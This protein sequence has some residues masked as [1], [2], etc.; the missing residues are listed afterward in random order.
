MQL[1]ETCTRRHRPRSRTR[2]RQKSPL[3]STFPKKSTVQNQSA[4]G[5][6]RQPF[7]FRK[8][9]LTLY[10][11]G[12]AP[13]HG[14]V[15]APFAIERMHS[16]AASSST[17]TEE[18]HFDKVGPFRC[19][20]IRQRYVL[21][22]NF[23]IDMPMSW[24]IPGTPRESHQRFQLVPKSRFCPMVGIIIMGFHNIDTVTMFRQMNAAYRPRCDPLRERQFQCGIFRVA[25]PRNTTDPV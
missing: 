9:Y 20:K 6:I 5:R 15:T 1:A 12:C 11:S 14:N 4:S 3:K 16:L 22:P 2:R 7:L 18:R 21:S 8:H 13:Y 24:T 25:A 10:R 17:V 23:E 19:S